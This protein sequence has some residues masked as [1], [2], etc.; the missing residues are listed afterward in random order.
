MPF[1]SP[2]FQWR[3]N[4][5]PRKKG[6]AHGTFFSC[7][8][9]PWSMV[10]YSWIE[11]CQLK[12]ARGLT[13]TVQL[14]WIDS[15]S[16]RENI[17]SVRGKCI[18]GPKRKERID[19]MIRNNNLNELWFICFE[20]SYESLRRITFGP[21]ERWSNLICE[22]RSAFLMMSLDWQIQPR[23]VR[24][25]MFSIPNIFCICSIASDI[26]Q[27][28][29]KQSSATRPSNVTTTSRLLSVAF[30]WLARFNMYNSAI[31]GSF[32]ESY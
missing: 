13:K 15:F 25:E 20:C 8:C 22:I 1:L 4:S 28:A 16:S 9:L 24:V 7:L 19:T 5:T 10:L 11:V 12:K 31:V 6:V 29:F 21:L 2:L 18:I 14:C 32:L 23:L 30:R 27:S 26:E 17:H 3:K